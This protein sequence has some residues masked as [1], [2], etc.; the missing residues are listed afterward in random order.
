[1][2]SKKKTEQP[3][4][5]DILPG[6]AR[7]NGW[8]FQLDLHS[9]FGKWETIADPDTAEHCRP[10]KI[11]RGILWLEV[12]NSAWLQQLR[13]MKYQLLESINSSLRQSRIEDI[14]YVLPKGRSP[15]KAADKGAIRFAPPPVLEIDKFKSQISFIGD[16]Q[17]REALFR[18]WY[19]ARACRKE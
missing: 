3:A 11:S 7:Q 19:L 16:E 4:V 12:D 10:L 17:C 5:A 6:L 18:F 8:E 2:R 9:I 15:Q 1:M 14:K 13:Y